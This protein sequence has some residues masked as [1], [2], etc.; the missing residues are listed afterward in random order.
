MSEVKSTNPKVMFDVDYLMELAMSEAKCLPNL[1]S[2]LTAKV[3][4]DHHDL[5]VGIEVFNS[6]EE[7]VEN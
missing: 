7:G 6:Q 4:Y 5:F 3:V 2:K 1:E